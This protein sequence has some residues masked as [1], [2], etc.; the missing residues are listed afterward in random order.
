MCRNPVLCVLLLG[1]AAPS[2]ARAA[3]ITV[4]FTG[5]VT[6]IDDPAT[7]LTDY[8]VG[9]FVRGS[10]TYE[11]GAFDV[12]PD[13]TLGN[14]GTSIPPGAFSITIG[15]V[16][17]VHVGTEVVIMVFNTDLEDTFLLYSNFVVPPPC[18]MGASA[19][20]LM[21]TSQ[22]AHSSDALPSAPPLLSSY[23]IRFGQFQIACGQMGISELLFEISS[24]T[25]VPVPTVGAW[26]IGAL[27]VLLTTAG[28]TI[29][30]RRTR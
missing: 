16:T 19:I 21:D 25:V 13:P 22:T 29:L 27:A 18:A 5:K 4:Y 12:D 9:D 26:G 11:S 15:S 24:M 2:V 8:Q 30:R 6:S 20:N 23:N 17:T 1:A 7:V 10:Y 14:Y 28:V 3:L